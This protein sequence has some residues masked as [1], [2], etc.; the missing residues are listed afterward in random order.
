M[1]IIKRSFA[2][3]LCIALVTGLLPVHT[4]ALDTG[5][6]TVT[7]SCDAGYF[8]DGTFHPNS[9]VVSAKGIG[10]IDISAV[11]ADGYDSVLMPLYGESCMY[12]PY[13][14]SVGGYSDGDPIT[15]TYSASMNIFLQEG[16]RVYYL[17][18]EGKAERITDIT[19]TET[20]I[21]ELPYL[22]VTFTTDR[23]GIFVFGN[24]DDSIEPDPE[25]T[26]P[27]TTVPETTAP[28]E[29]TA[30]ADPSS[31]SESTEPA[32]LSWNDEHVT[33]YAAAVGLTT[34]IAETKIYSALNNM[35]SDYVCYALSPAGHAEGNTVHY[36]IELPES[37]DFDNLALYK[38]TVDGIT[39]LEFELNGNFIS[40]QHTGAGT[41][42]CGVAAI[43][44]GY[45]L[46]GLELEGNLPADCFIGED[47]NMSGIKVIA[48]FEKD[49]DVFRR[50]LHQVDSVQADGYMVTA[51]TSVPGETTVYVTYGTAISKF[52]IQVHQEHFTDPDTGITV[53]VSEFG[54]EEMTVTVLDNSVFAES[55]L[56]D[57][58]ENFVAYD[59][60]LTGYTQGDYATVTLPIPEG[61][62][63]PAVFY[64]SDDGMDVVMLPSTDN[65]DGTVSFVTNHFSTYAVGSEGASGETISDTTTIPGTTLDRVTVT[66]PEAKDEIWKK[67]DNVTSG[68]DY[69]IVNTGSVGS[70]NA[71]A[72]NNTNGISVNV[73]S[74]DSGLYI[75]SVSNDD[76]IWT[77]DES[78]GT[79]SFVNNGTYI[80][81]S[82]TEEED[83]G[84]TYYTN[85]FAFSSEKH[86]WSIGQN[87]LTVNLITYRGAITGTRYSD[88]YLA[89]QNN[90]WTMAV[91]NA[92]IYFYEYAQIVTRQ[93]ATYGIDILVNGKATQTHSAKTY[94][95]TIPLSAALTTTVSGQ[96]PTG[97]TYNWDDVTNNGVATVDANG[98]VTLSGTAGQEAIKVT[99]TWREGNTDCS[100]SNYIVISVEAPVY[101][102]VITS[103]ENTTYKTNVNVTA[104]AVI[105]R[106]GI[107]YITDGIK[108]ESN[109]EDVVT[110][111]DGKLNIIKAGTATLTVTAVN[112]DNNAET[113]QET[114]TV[115]FVDPTYYFELISPPDNYVIKTG[116]KT[117]IVAEA[118]ADEDII[119]NPTITWKS[120]NEAVA[121]VDQ[122]GVV[123]GVAAS[124][125]PVTITATYTDPLNNVH[126]VTRTIYVA[127]AV[128]EV[129]LSPADA[130]VQIGRSYVLLP[131]LYDGESKVEGAAFTWE[132][133]SP[134]IVDI[135]ASGII[136][137]R[138]AGQTVVTAVY[139]DA[140]GRVFK[141]ID[142]C[143]ITVTDAVYDLDLQ[144]P[145]DDGN[146]GTKLESITKPIALKNVK[147]GDTYNVW[148]VI[149]ADGTDIGALSEAQLEYLTWTTSNSAIA[150]IDPKTGIITFQGGE[151]TVSISAY[152]E[153]EDGKSVTD[154]VVIS[155]SK[156][157]YTVEAD[158]TNDFP[159]YP[160][161]GSIRYDKTATAV[162]NFSDT[163][164]VQVELSM[165]GVP[166]TTGS[167]IDVVIMLDMSTSMT[168]ARVT[169]ARESAIAAVDAIV[170]NEDGTYNNNRIA[171]YTFCA[172]VSE[173]VALTT[174]SESNYTSVINSIN[175]EITKNNTDSGTNYTASLK[176]CQ[177][178]LA[179]AKQTEIGANRKQFCIFVSDGAPT[180]GFTYVN[181]NGTAKE[182]GD[183]N[184]GTGN[185][186][187][188]D[189]NIIAKLVNLDE[190]YSRQMKNAG[191]AVYTVGVQMNATTNAVKVLKNIAGTQDGDGSDSGY[192]NYARLVTSDQDASEL[193]N[194]FN[195]ITQ[196]IKEA[197]RDV[198]V[199][200]E[201]DGHFTMIFESPND[202]VTEV[203]GNQKYFI[204][205]GE[206]QLNAVPD[207]AGNIT[208]YS[209][210]DYNSLLK[211]Y[212][213]TDNNTYYAAS[214][215]NGTKYA[216]PVFEHKTLGDSGSMFYWTTTDISSR[217]DYSGVSV[218]VS[219]TTYYFDPEGKSNK[220]D[221]WDDLSGLW[222]NM[223]SGAYANGTIDPNAVIENRDGTTEDL[224][225]SHNLIIATPYFVYNAN[226]RMLV[227][228]LD[229]LNNT[230]M[231][232]RYFLYLDDSAGY[233]DS[234][235]QIESGTYDT[236]VRAELTYTNFQDTDC[237]KEL[238]VPKVT[239]HGAQVSYVFYLV[240]DNGQPVN[241]AGRVV[242]LSEA[243]YVT[244]VHTESI[245][246][247]EE[248]LNGLEASRLA[249][250]LV[251]DVYS[252]YD[253]GAGYR[254]HVY[255]D[256]EGN[257]LTNHFVIESG[258]KTHTTYV[259]NKK[260]DATWYKD[261]GVYI[262][263]GHDDLTFTCKGEGTITGNDP[264]SYTKA[265][266][267][268][269]QHIF[270]TEPNNSNFVS[271]TNTLGGMYAYFNDDD[272][273]IYT[274]VDKKADYEAD[275]NFDFAN[276]TVAFAV[277]WK[278]E[279]V[280]DT[281]V[282]DFGLDVEVNVIEND[283]LTAG[284][285][286]VRT[287]APN[288]EINK[289]TFAE[290]G[291]LK[292]TMIEL[293][294][295]NDIVGTAS[296]A[297]L[298]TIRI[299]LNKGN[300]MKLKSP[301]TFYYEAE[302][303]YYTE[304][305]S[306]SSDT[307]TSEYM[308][309]SVT[310][311]P[312]TTIYYEDEYVQLSTENKGA[313]GWEKSEKSAWIAS[314]P[315]SAVQSTDRPGESKISQIYDADNLYGSDPAYQ[316][317][318]TYSLGNSASITVDA[319]HRGEASF[320]FWGTG[321][322]IIG[323]T[324]NQTG[325][326]MVQLYE[327][328]DTS[329]AFKDTPKLNHIVD[330][331]YGY[332]REAAE[333]KFTDGKWHH[334]I[335]KEINGETNV[336]YVLEDQFTVNF[337]GY[338]TEGKTAS[339]YV[340]K[341][342]DS[343]AKNDL[344][345]IPVMKISGQPYGKYKAKLLI[346]YS[347]TF[348]H[349]G[350]GSYDF[351]LDA[352]RIYDPAGTDLSNKPEVENAYKADG[353][354]Y[355]K[356]FEPRN[357]I[358]DCGTF[359]SLTSEAISG[360]VFIDGVGESA[361][362]TDYKNF[363]PNNE[364]YL[365]Q[366]HAISFKL[367][368]GTVQSVQIGLKSVGA[369]EAKAS[370][371]DVYTQYSPTVFSLNTATDMYYNI[372]AYN[373]KTVVIQNTGVGIL[374]ITNVKFTYDSP[375][376]VPSK[377]ESQQIMTVSRDSIGAVLTAMRTLVPSD[378]PVTEPAEPSEPTV[379]EVSIPESTVPETTQPETSAPVRPGSGT[380]KPTKPAET[381]P[382]DTQP[383]ETVPTVTEPEATEAETVPPCEPS[384]TD[385]QAKSNVMETESPEMEADNSVNADTSGES[386]T[387]WEIIVDILRN[388]LRFIAGI[389]GG[390]N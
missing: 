192:E 364:V 292:Q 60:D 366:N 275:S 107:D 17:S 234:M 293:K 23:V 94:D 195:S 281:V 260:S 198:K 347:D 271:K 108:W 380:T 61:V 245:T 173:V 118:K 209:R 205:V 328:D 253:P 172:S 8:E 332:T 148:A 224:T 46:T 4:I 225:V 341:I 196:E 79:Y 149:T 324:S 153:Y 239:W 11:W 361:T 338:A 181:T 314:T 299:S 240:N 208:D 301:V 24:I 69:L 109:N 248:L 140:N 30:P 9:D 37:Y 166:Y 384:E 6:E 238:P 377:A 78:D 2:M 285:V 365:A 263:D 128:Y 344:Y 378:P 388:F 29:T 229:K 35:F 210:G 163:G 178:L 48:V 197:A 289:G 182:Y 154:T 15:I 337:D 316:Q 354:A 159:E 117:Q 335:T 304:T 187:N 42:A 41:F 38:I 218:T 170:K 12:S 291:A 280:E 19:V 273:T 376:N 137:G 77:A 216:D 249:E 47:I 71:I 241:R 123:T 255:D 134:D 387:L 244:S 1:S 27:E 26:N 59:I 129:R 58:L 57:Y 359:G 70:G 261:P 122:N 188:H 152:Y 157:G 115:T 13:M 302:V 99:Y 212:M 93:E 102:L 219:G 385:E 247:T 386:M 39:A 68:R 7:V 52:Q 220:A 146:G 25:E 180:T 333:F 104:S 343:G 282:I 221:D 207:T 256:A 284:V 274:I 306:Y 183:S 190:Y 372:T 144:Q 319:T 90:A 325:I 318:S 44:R 266:G 164:I 269:S 110:V 383:T 345:Q 348:D 250:G 74:N 84:R 340:W 313:N 217:E 315:A 50:V 139:T 206:Y 381:E 16:I 288:A 88:Y 111:E 168:T 375:S 28:E 390:R 235:D 142:T 147:V 251:P 141:S 106:D 290:S 252:L 310:V 40:F 22:Q 143:T 321:F 14:I 357:W 236:N 54:T 101:N 214:D 150:T 213:G 76:T 125:E 175:K 298:N 67:V 201:I 370:I 339:G 98:L 194:V 379:P 82:T 358:I 243:V 189:S 242:P 145:V 211:L 326:L 80:G 227:W 267:E 193:K 186:N 215:A 223:S 203:A 161:E 349:T 130:T 228:T 371:W 105:K 323:V 89:Y 258:V 131:E 20:E 329:K 322:D 127:D 62:E 259:F 350:R 120:S 352:I 36:G 334:K 55:S 179:D 167:E 116:A 33:I 204:E 191:V 389:F 327:W 360:A 311:I 95:G 138:N 342:S 151:G 308:Y 382:S 283:A 232:L 330:T 303:N 226:T 160:N 222:Y 165:T 185:E 135:T 83:W 297:N 66:V 346:R 81:W 5:K 53:E 312:A 277:V 355:P 136:V 254:I 276:T 132:C 230:E 156:D 272:G 279:L 162:G 356:Y 294:N 31:P 114:V 174:V 246:W 368:G 184:L 262:P 176:K 320:E 18:S 307:L 270:T 103:P 199:T 96:L 287:S 373:D 331:Y 362:V 121:A 75:A 87:L 351:Y 113:L 64:V 51:D 367:D 3:L 21:D 286:G 158:G 296:V 56:P 278:P 92:D 63:H 97:G 155:V 309:S 112:P 10:L 124:D 32:V 295:D 336:E 34:L 126:E 374:S 45:P 317:C 353:E 177:T 119:S 72:K 133:S 264:Y 73:L 202:H 200:D 268:T 369:G 237:S 86:N 265:D 305:D 171:V 169:S 91:A 300:S 49:G 65:G 257:H 85:T 363:G 43:P 231:A 233:D 100:V